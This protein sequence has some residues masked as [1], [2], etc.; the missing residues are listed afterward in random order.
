MFEK[1]PKYFSKKN[2]KS[3]ALTPFSLIYE[4]FFLLCNIKFSKPKK[5]CKK[6]ICV[7]NIVCGG[8][9]K[10]P[11]C[12]ALYK[13]FAS[14]QYK[15][16]F[17]TKGYRRT[18]NTNII[19]PKKHNSFYL[20]KEIGD[21]ASFLCRY[22]DT[23]IVQHRG[24]AK[25]FAYDITI[26]DDGFFTKSVKKNCNIAVFD[27]EYFIGNGFTLPA[28]PMRYNLHAIKNADFIIITNS[29]DIHLLK[30]I[31]KL[32][33]YIQKSH[34]LQA[35]LI[36]T[37]KH[38]LKENYF[39]FSGI[40]HNNKFFNTLKSLK[41]NIIGLA[42]FEDHCR[43]TKKQIEKLQISIL[44]SG[45]KRAIT[46]S[47]DYVKLPQWFITKFNIEVLQIEYEIKGVEKINNFLK[48]NEEQ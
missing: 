25:C 24:E 42:Q 3:L 38:S 27:A 21:E 30:C 23:F 36:V 37:S 29:K 9:G 46:T 18:T 1:K 20:N 44:C 19:V 6:T 31:E 45:A 11:I 12:I 5:I 33:K 47:K 41:I 43:Y 8:S 10:T 7:G 32:Q 14:L 34:I 17:I 26:M 28:G 35:D 4:I 40:G 22:A 13:Y 2:C 15:V 39:A 48:I 16:C